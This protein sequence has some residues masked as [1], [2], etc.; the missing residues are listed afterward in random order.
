MLVIRL[1][2]TGRKNDPT[3]RIVVAEKS[4]AVKGKTI[5]SIG[6]YLPSR[7]TPEVVIAKDKV[8]EW[9]KKGAKPSNTLARLCKKHGMEGMDKFIQRYA[10]QKPKNPEPEAAPAA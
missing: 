8:A 4:S 6:H 3:Y 2:R 9:V 1:Q 5:D 10:K 7:T